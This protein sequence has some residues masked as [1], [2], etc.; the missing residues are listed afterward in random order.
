MATRDLHVNITLHFQGQPE[1]YIV[2]SMQDIQFPLPGQKNPNGK[3]RYKPAAMCLREWL[4][5]VKK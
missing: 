1:C 5:K 3:P 2:D 4:S